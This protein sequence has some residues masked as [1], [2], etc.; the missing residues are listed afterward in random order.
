MLTATFACAKG[1]NEELERRLWQ[2]GI[3]NW[4]MARAY[5]DEVE[6]LIGQ[7]RARR[8]AEWIGE[9]ERALARRDR[10]WFKTAFAEAPWR[11]WRDYC[12]PARIALLDIETNGLTPGFDQI[13]VIG[14]VDGERSRAFVAGTPQD[15][16]LP[17]SQFPAAVHEYDL[18]VTFNGTGFDIP[19]L[20]RQFRDF[21]LRF[22]AP[23]FDLMPLAHR[24]GF[25]G[26]LKDIEA[27]LGIVRERDIAGLRGGE[28]IALWAAWRQGDAGAYQRLVRYCLAD[29][30][31]LRQ[32]AEAL[33]SRCRS[34]LYE[35]HARAIDFAGRK[36][37]QMSLFDA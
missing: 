22:D 30:A 8:L 35:A 4:Q 13:T 26:G 11:L 28:A 25:S 19:F 7:A 3:L 5:P 23:H 9:A 32:V 15:G 29:C 17:L 6:A 24:L 33:Y 10:A 16:H 12:P 2:G 18:I 27:Q 37:I 21:G 14:L 20:E 1:L 34:A 31:H 36:G